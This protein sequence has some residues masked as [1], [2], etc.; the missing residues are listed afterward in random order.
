MGEGGRE[1]E[2]EENLEHVAGHTW[3]IGELFRGWRSKEIVVP[4][5]FLALLLKMNPVYSNVWR[6]ASY[7]I[8]SP[9]SFSTSVL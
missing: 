8:P 2:K 9:N 6:C 1:A 4:A 3:G 5:K 7:S